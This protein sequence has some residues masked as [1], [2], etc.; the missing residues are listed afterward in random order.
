MEFIKKEV[1]IFVI[2]GKAGTGKNTVMQLI[3]NHYQEKTCR[4]LAYANYLKTYAKQISNWDGEEETKPRALLQQ[5]GVE[6]I[7]TNIDEKMLI[8]RIIED[9]KVYSYFFD[10]ITISDARFKEEIE[11]IQKTFENVTTIRVNRERD[12]LTINEK[13]H[14]TEVALD[15][16]QN[17]DFIIDNNSTQE[18]LESKIQSI[19]EEVK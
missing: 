16:Y 15:D 19:L 18:A 5:L 12:H 2:S 4:N 6:L 1:K 7:K 14:K 10:I 8:R 3:H 9:I 17:Y 11:D 13:K